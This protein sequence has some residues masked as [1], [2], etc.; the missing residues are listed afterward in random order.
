MLGKPALRKSLLPAESPW[1]FTTH[2]WHRA[3]PGWKTVGTSSNRRAP[4][5]ILE[6]AIKQHFTYIEQGHDHAFSSQASPETDGSTLT[7]G[8]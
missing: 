7:R 1:T 3:I 8:L 5:V 4:G 2:R 6:P